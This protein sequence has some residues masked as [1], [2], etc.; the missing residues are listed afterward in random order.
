MANAWSPSI[1]EQEAWQGGGP[2]A[3]H[4]YP[5]ALHAAQQSTGLVVNSAGRQQPQCSDQPTQS[6]F[7]AIQKGLG[8]I[9]RPRLVHPY[10]LER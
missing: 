1:A 7:A 10:T 3:P 4:V 8:I 2:S 9:H 6:V 5:T